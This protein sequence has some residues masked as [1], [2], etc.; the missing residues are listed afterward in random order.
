MALKL[1]LP[2]LT[3]RLQPH[4][5]LPLMEIKTKPKSYIAGVEYGCCGAFACCLSIAATERDVRDHRNEGSKIRAASSLLV[6]TFNITI[7]IFICFALH[8]MCGD[9]VSRIGRVSIL[10]LVPCLLTN[11]CSIIK[12]FGIILS[13]AM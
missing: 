2:L 5:V 11:A 13:I 9:D 8:M 12:S 6:I 7:F 1:T 4:N 3:P 10:V